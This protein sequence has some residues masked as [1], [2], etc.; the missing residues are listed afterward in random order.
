MKFGDT[1]TEFL[2]K[3]QVRFSEKCSHVE[4][5][6]LKKV[7]K[8]CQS[9]K[10]LQEASTADQQEGAANQ[11]K[12]L[13]QCQSC[14]AC[15]QAFFTELM[16]EVSDI[17]LCFSLRVRHLL[18]LHVATGMQ[19]YLLW[20]RQCFMNDQQAMVEKGRTL[21]EYVTMNAIAIRKILKK[22][23]KV[24]SSENGK[25]FKSKMR[26]EHIE[27]LQSP[28]LIEL[29]AFSL[30][31]HGSDGEGLNELS[32]HFSCDLDMTPPIMTLMLPDSLKM[33]YDLTCAVCL[34]TVFNPY[35]LSCGHLFCKSCACSAA[36]VFIFQGP[37]SAALDAKCPICRE[38]G[39]YAKAV[40]ML[41]LDLLLKI[42]CKDYWKERYTAER[43]E[44]LKQ[45]KEFWDLQA[46]YAVY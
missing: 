23:D 24:H 19:R 43:A 11:N 18:H 28:W 6:R 9:C 7:L 30:N 45:S 10:T 31:L 3:E 20:L 25:I 17:A 15:D 29:G 12:Q 8:T 44:I 35:A 2:H 16:K 14:P 4:Y 38:A 46:K 34:E 13:C 39:V 26:A 22:Y 33:E 37:K 42:R 41:E 27:L 5:K 36:S 1:F 21:I 32:G 40:H